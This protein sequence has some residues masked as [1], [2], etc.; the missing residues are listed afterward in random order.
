VISDD[1][2]RISRVQASNAMRCSLRDSF[3]RLCNTLLLDGA[4]IISSSFRSVQ[5]DVIVCCNDTD[6]TLAIERTLALEIEVLTWYL[7][8]ILDASCAIWNLRQQTQAHH[9][10]SLVVCIDLVAMNSQV[11]LQ[12]QFDF[13]SGV[14]SADCNNPK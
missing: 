2:A 3:C 5:I 1:V 10:P 13:C 8:G 14:A 12:M 11:L 6:L 4:E 7:C 9:I